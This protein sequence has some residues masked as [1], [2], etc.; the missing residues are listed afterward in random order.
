MLEEH[1]KVSE[2]QLTAMRDVSVVLFETVE[3]AVA[4][5][6]AINGKKVQTQGRVIVAEFLELD[7]V[8]AAGEEK[9]AGRVALLCMWLHACSCL[10]ACHC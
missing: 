4:A 5:Y 7:Y 8:S 10:L 9:E 3:G 6:Q 2:A 1:G